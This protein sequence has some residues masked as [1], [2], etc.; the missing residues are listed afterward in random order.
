MRIWREEIFGPVLC[1]RTF[2]TEAEALALANGLP[3]G[4]AAGVITADA[5]RADRVAAALEAGI[6]WQNCS[7]PCFVQAPWGGTKDSGFGRE[8]GPFGLDSFLSV[9][10]VTTYLAPK[11]WDWFPEGGPSPARL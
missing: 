7:Q 5:G 2:G 9:K 8:L 3:F 1:A 4:L 6:V 10:Q 11:T